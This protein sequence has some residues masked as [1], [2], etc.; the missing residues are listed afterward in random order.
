M[1]PAGERRSIFEIGCGTGYYTR[2]LRERYRTARLK[3]C[4]I[5]A[6]MVE[7]AREKLR[8][9]AIE[10]LVADAETLVLDER[11]DLVTSNA[12]LQWFEDL[13][14]AL[15]HCRNAL[16]DGG[17]LA[18]S[19][20]GPETFRELDHCLRL[21]L[22]RAEGGGLVR[23]RTFLEKERIA[24]MLRASFGRVTV[25]DATLRE[26]YPSLRALLEKIKYTGARGGG[27]AG[28]LR[29]RAAGLRRTGGEALRGGVRPR[30]GDVS[31]I[32]FPGGTMS[33]IFV[34][35]T[36]TGVGKT[37]VTGLLARHLSLRGYRVATQKWV[38]TGGAERPGRAPALDGPKPKRFP[39]L[40]A[41]DGPGGVR[42]RRSRR[43]S[44][45]N[46]AA[47]GSPR[48]GSAAPSCASRGI[49]IS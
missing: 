21:A 26:E 4:D 41:R 19:I 14:A 35:G 13:E 15:K 25:R 24:E 46:W 28:R 5:S 6:R 27:L 42:R 43:T 33:A 18:F 8:D 32:P 2:L 11:F 37:V 47:R 10:F 7:V 34:A 40:P 9:E 1:L 39:R 22:G 44:P 49:S 30:R 16:N 38:Q 23:S 29:A 17:L 48:A 36:D 20:F 3:A 45:R 31:G 12:T